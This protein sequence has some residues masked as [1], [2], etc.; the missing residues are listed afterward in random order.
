M[1]T[2]NVRTGLRRDLEEESD[3]EDEDDEGDEGAG[4]DG[5][6]PG[7]AG[8]QQARGL[9]PE[10]LLWFA[11]RGDFEVPPNVEYER[12]TG[13]FRG[14]EGVRIPPEPMHVTAPP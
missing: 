5:A 8:T 2:E 10:T 12:K 13:A 6:A 1:G 4:G 9:E 7:Q 11:A 3:D 14:L